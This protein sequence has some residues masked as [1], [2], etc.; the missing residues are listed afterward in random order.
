MSG[1]VI[2]PSSVIEHGSVL[3]DGVEIGPFCVVGPNVVLNDGVKL[4]S[5]VTI[6]GHTNIGERTII[7]PYAA[8]GGPP[9]HRG[10]NGE[11]TTLEIGIDCVIRE[12]VSV[13]IGMPSGHGRTVIG[14]NCMLMTNSHLGHDCCINDNVL[15]GHNAGLAGHVTIQE[16]ASIGPMAG[17]HQFVRIGAF[18]FVGGCAAVTQ[19]LIPYGSAVGNHAAL[20]G[21]NII[22]LKR[23]GLERATIHKMRSAYSALFY[24]D[25]V[26]VFAERVAQVAKDYSDIPEIVRIIE[27]IHGSKKRG[28]MMAR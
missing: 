26:G 16:G 28:L 13:H 25:R 14:N 11:P 2:H 23:S 17:I 15:I 12:G 1:P 20:G 6:E 4:Q 18:S 27:F 8:L 10:Y 9:Q 21:L 24:D 19:D 7:H 5:H 22:G 3:G